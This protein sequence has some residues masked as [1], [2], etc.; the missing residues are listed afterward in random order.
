MRATVEAAAKG[1]WKHALAVA[2]LVA[3]S[4]SKT[5]LYG[6]AAPSTDEQDKALADIKEYALN[7]A[8]SLPYYTCIRIT[9]QK[10]SAVIATREELTVAG[11]RE[12]Y[13]ILKTMNK[14]PLNVK[15]VDE[16]FG[17]IAVGEFSAVLGRIFAPDT[18]A[19]SVGFAPASCAASRCLFS[20]LKFRKRMGRASSTASNGARWLRVTRA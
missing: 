16:D 9:Q 10:G 13:K 20:L 5:A 17:T 1:R 8:H 18:G 6:Q 4:S 3:F 12:T 19:S 7:Y 11:N 2:A 15:V 14:V